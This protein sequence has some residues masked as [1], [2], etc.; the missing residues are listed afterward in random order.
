M[1]RFIKPRPRK[2]EG[3]SK[4]IPKRKICAFCAEK[5][6]VI[7]YKDAKLKRYVSERGK[8]EPRR[9]SGACAKHQRTL[10]VAIK[11]ARFLA[12]IPYAPVHIRKYGVTVSHSWQ[13]GNSR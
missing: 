9:R 1:V 4:Y 5:A 3:G 11:R 2:R 6:N 10:A 13:P 8:I 7:D 12:L